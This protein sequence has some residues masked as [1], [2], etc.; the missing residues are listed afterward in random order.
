M[1]K[2]RAPDQQ[3]T[4]LREHGN[5]ICDRSKRRASGGG[6]DTTKTLRWGYNKGAEEGSGGHKITVALIQ[7]P[8]FLLLKP[9][10]TTITIQS[11]IK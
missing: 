6:L 4:E 10:N 8:P 2:D 5:G 1:K 3:L 7:Q 9:A 11:N